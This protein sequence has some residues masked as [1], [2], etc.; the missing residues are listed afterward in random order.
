MQHKTIANSLSYIHAKSRKNRKL[1]QLTIDNKVL[2]KNSESAN[3]CNK[4][5]V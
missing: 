5:M 1:W 2:F 3:T 4:W